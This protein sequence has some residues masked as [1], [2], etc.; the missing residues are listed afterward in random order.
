MTV[1]PQFQVEKCGFPPRCGTV[2]Q[3]FTLGGLLRW[4]WETAYMFFMAEGLQLCT[5]GNRVG[6]AL[7][8]CGEE[9]TDKGKGFSLPFALRSNP[10]QS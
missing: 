6:L 8:C 3:I 5:P 1:K 4:S 10:H 9:G 7:Y 2:D